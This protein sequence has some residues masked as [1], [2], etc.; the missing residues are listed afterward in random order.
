MAL[1]NS[2][3]RGPN[4]EGRAAAG[5]ALTRGETDADFRGIRPPFPYRDHLPCL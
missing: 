4:A 5:L 3:I 2:A 1:I